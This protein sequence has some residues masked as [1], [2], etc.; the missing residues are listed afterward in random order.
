MDRSEVDQ[1]GAITKMK[2]TLNEFL[3]VVYVCMDVRQKKRGTTRRKKRCKVALRDGERARETESPDEYHL[4]YESEQCAQQNNVLEDCN[5]ESSITRSHVD[6]DKISSRSRPG[7]R[8]G[9]APVPAWRVAR[10]TAAGAACASSR[11][12]AWTRPRTAGLSPHSSC[13][14]TPDAGIS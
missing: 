13:Q 2:N 5:T 4:D 1:L 3:D 7:V 11:P 14:W 6:G 12:Q 9:T 8:L 10:G